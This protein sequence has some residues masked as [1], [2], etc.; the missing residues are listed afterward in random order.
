MKL[1]DEHKAYILKNI[2]G[3]EALIENDEV[4]TLL[5]L[6]NDIIIDEEME[7]DEPTKLSEFLDEIYDYIDANN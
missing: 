1:K 2:E 6:I 7:H 4:D 3:A 5:L